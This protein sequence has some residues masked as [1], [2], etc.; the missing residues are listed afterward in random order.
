[1]SHKLENDV[2]IF[3]HDVIATFFDVVLFLLSSLVTGSRFMWIIVQSLVQELWQFSFIKNWSK[4]RKL[5]I[6]QTELCRIFG[7]WSQLGIPSLARMSLIKCYLMLQNAI[8]QPLL[9]LSYWG[10]TNRGSK[11]TPPRL[12]LVFK[13]FDSTKYQNLTVEFLLLLFLLYSF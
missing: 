7:D 1:M 3:Q 13:W 4:I 11:I 5:Q 8:L 2:T 12:G 9:F 10:K 6:S